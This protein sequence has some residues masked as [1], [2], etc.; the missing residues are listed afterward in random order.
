MGGYSCAIIADEITIRSSESGILI[1]ARI[2][3]KKTIIGR[4]LP[5]DRILA[6]IVDKLYAPLRDFP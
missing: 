1:P 5:V 3:R 6:I 4:K 2:R